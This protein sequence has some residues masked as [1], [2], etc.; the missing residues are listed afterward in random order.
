MRAEEGSR[1]GEAIDR[2]AMRARLA[3]AGGGWRNGD[4][5]GRGGGQG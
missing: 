3:A 1:E 2:G 5:S 4:G